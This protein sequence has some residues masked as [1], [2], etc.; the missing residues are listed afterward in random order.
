L[1]L[2]RVAL[3]DEYFVKR[4]LYPNLDFYSGIVMRAIGIPISMFTVIFAVSR[5]VGWMAQ[6]MEMME[7][8]TPR[9]TRPR[10]MYMGYM[11]RS[12]D[13]QD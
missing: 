11:N 3:E 9:I 7:E 4:N 5:S 6:W 1:E 12:I 13:R 10:Q 8:S 2:E